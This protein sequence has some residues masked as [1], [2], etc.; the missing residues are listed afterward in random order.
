M[1]EWIFGKKEDKKEEKGEPKKEDKKE[2]EL[3]KDDKWIYDYVRQY[4]SSPLWRNPLLDFI[5][6][7]SLIFED[8]EENKFEYTKI[9]QEFTGLTSLLLESMIE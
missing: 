2:D 3:S 5:E 9:F 7:N 8:V 4:L 6:E 1:F